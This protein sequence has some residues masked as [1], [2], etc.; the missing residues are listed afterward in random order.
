M[1]ALFIL[2]G[3]LAT[4]KYRAEYGYSGQEMGK[5]ASFTA[6]DQVG[7]KFLWKWKLPHVIP[8]MEFSRFTNNVEEDPTRSQT[9]ATRQK[10]SLNW[11]LPDWPSLALTYSREQ[12][13]IF[14]RPEGSLTDATSTESTLAKLSIQ[15]TVGSGAWSWHYKTTEH[16]F[17]ESRKEKEIGSTMDGTFHLFAPIDFTPGW[18]FTR[19]EN[20]EGTLAKDRFIANLETKIFATSTLTLNPGFKFKRDQ[21]RFNAMKTDT[22]SAN[23]GYSYH[24]SDDSLQVSMLGQYILNKTSNTAANPQSY[25]LT[26]LV[27][28]DLG[29]FFNLAHRQQTLSLKIA[30]NQQINSLS[31]EAQGAQTSAMLLV[32]IAP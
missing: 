17:G 5:A 2:K 21:D 29:H 7:G 13:D 15:H 22:L 28:K 8:K 20:A 14:T 24:A 26:F 3:D 18:E 30:H 10:F 19:R 9:I 23:L 1:G 32:S 12:K 11:K 4:M 27:E 25:D 6:T 16:D 31:A